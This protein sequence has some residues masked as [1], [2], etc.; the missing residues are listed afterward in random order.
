ML[1]KIDIDNHA[2]ILLYHGVTSSR[3]T[4]IKNC[5]GKHIHRDIFEQQMKLISTKCN[6]VSLRSL[7]QMLST[8][9]ALPKNTVAITFDD[10][11]QNVYQN[12][13]PILA[14]YHIPAT[15]FITAG[16]VN[17]S[18][19]IWADILEKTIAALKSKQIVLDF[20]NESK[21]YPISNKSEKIKALFDIKSKLKQIEDT[22]KNKFMNYFVKK[23][24]E[25]IAESDTDLYSNLSWEQL[26]EMDS[27]T[28]FEIGSHTLNHVILSQVDIQKARMEIV[29]SK[30]TLESHLNHSINLF[31]YP[32]G[33]EIHY[34]ENIIQILKGNNFVCSPSA[35]WGDN[36]L[37]DDPFHLK[38]IMVGFNNIAFPY[39]DIQ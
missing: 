2:I 9:K 31:S 15:F 26:K 35:I 10:C 21:T 7:V 12:A 5:S 1:P 34:N 8:S 17:T 11:F 27:N 23:F 30:K 19:I 24:Q 32:E 36:S 22:Q 4:D 38:R 13:Y 6:P 39:T 29:E 28:L 33:Q 3:H 18:K 20:L 16:Y 14:K 25:P 37:G